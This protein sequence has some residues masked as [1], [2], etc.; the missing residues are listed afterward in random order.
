VHGTKKHIYIWGSVEVIA[1]CFLHN[2][3]LHLPLYVHVNGEIHKSL[4]R[5]LCHF[6]VF[7]LLALSVQL[8]FSTPLFK[9]NFYSSLK[10][11]A[12]LSR[13]Q[14]SKIMIFIF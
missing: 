5:L 4:I 1:T 3:P 14:I 8:F 10:A 6:A 9:H 13:P 11:T 7:F 12:K 2:L